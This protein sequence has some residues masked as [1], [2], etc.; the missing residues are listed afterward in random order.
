MNF[1]IWGPTRDDPRWPAIFDAL[2]GCL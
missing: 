1:M 2:Y